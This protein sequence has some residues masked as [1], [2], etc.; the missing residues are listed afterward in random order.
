MT[1][2]P[3]R[4]AV[5]L[6]L[7]A[8]LVLAAGSPVPRVIPVNAE[9]CT[10][11][12]RAAPASSPSGVAETVPACP[13]GV[14]CEPCSPRA[15]D[16]RPMSC[17]LC[18]RCL[19]GIGVLAPGVALAPPGSADLPFPPA[20]QPPDSHEEEPGGPPPKRAA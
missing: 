3:G 2:R 16:G 4:I 11:V 12:G 6:L 9:T 7:L 17:D 8:G 5:A 19:C 14:P 10:D 1:P 18:V 13:G 20:A 15:S